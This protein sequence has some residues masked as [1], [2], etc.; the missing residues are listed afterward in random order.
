MRVVSMF[1]CPS[2]PC[3]SAMS[4]KWSGALV[5]AVARNAC[6]PIPPSE[7][8]TTTRPVRISLN[9]IAEQLSVVE[10]S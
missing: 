9:L 6:A 2:H 10:S 7:P 1:A 8:G 4:A 3:T 5:T